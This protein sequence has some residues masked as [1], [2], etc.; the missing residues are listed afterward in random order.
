VAIAGQVVDGD[1]NPVAGAKVTPWAA[2]NPSET[3]ISDATGAFALTL[4]VTPRDRAF[5]ATVER[6]GYETSELWRSLDTATSTLLRIHRIQRIGAG[7]SAHI[8]I[9]TDDTACGYHWG[10]ICRRVRIVS[11]VAGTLTIEII[12]DANVQIGM[13]VGP[14][15][16]PQQLERRRTLAVTAGSETVAEV[17]AESLASASSFVLTTALGPH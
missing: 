11:E 9:D 7:D 6:A 4:S 14:D 2:Y 5:S 3:A 17:A 16:F 15:A 12:A 1:G 10:Y 13:L 8:A